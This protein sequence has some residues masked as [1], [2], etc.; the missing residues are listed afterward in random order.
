MLIA[1]IS[2]NNYNGI[3][4]FVNRFLKKFYFKIYWEKE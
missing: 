4:R 1:Y 3:N 2:I